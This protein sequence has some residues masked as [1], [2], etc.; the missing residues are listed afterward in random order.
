MYSCVPTRARRVGMAWRI[1]RALKPGGLFV[2]HSAGH[3]A[4]RES[5]VCGRA[6]A[7]CTLGNLAYEAGDTRGR[8]SSSCH[9][10]ASEDAVRSELEEGG[11]PCCASRQTDT[12]RS[13][14]VC[15]RSPETGQN[16]ECEEERTVTTLRMDAIYNTLDEWWRARLRES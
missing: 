7:A 5:W 16:A 12:H 4:A 1:A 2:C 13:G 14:A 6:V 15:R 8:I 10:F 11:F 9:Q 3:G